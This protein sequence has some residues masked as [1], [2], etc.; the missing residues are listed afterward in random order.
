LLSVSAGDE[1]SNG[2]CFYLEIGGRVTNH[3]ADPFFEGL[4]KQLGWFLDLS[5]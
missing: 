4:L 2:I 3:R 1:I 5:F